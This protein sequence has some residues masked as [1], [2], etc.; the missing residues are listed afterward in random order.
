MM[1][2]NKLL[3]VLCALVAVIAACRKTE[4]YK[5]STK[6][7]IDSRIVSIN[8]GADTTKFIVYA[9]GDWSMA[10]VE[11][12]NWMKLTTSS[13]SGKG[14]A[15]AELTDN[16]ANLPRFVRLVV[17]ADGKTDTIRL[18]QRGL[19]PT[20]AIADLTAQ[21]IANGG[22]FKTPINTNIPMELMTV[23][24]TARTEGQANWISNLRIDKGYLYFKADTNRAATPRTTMVRLSYLDALNV[25]V[26]DTIAI[27]QLPG[28]DY[29][30]AT[31]RDFDYVKQTL[32][33][34]VVNES[35]FIEGVVIS[36]KGHPNMAQ[37]QNTPANKHVLTKNENAIAVYV[38]SM[39]GT[40]GIYF[41]TKTPGDN[42][43]NINDRVKIWLKGATVERYNDPNRTIVT[44][45][46]TMHI[47]AKDEGTPVTPREKYMSELT[48]NDLYTLIKLKDVEISIP[49]G[50][51]TN[52]NEGYTARMDCYPTSI[53][54]IQGGSM[55]MLT[56]LDVPYRRDGKQVPQGSGSISGV[57][58]HE[59]MDRFGGNIGRYSIRHMKRE[60]IA[61]QE[62]RS[63]GFSNVLVEWSRFRNEF[64]A[65][66]TAEANPLTPEIGKGRIYHSTR[67]P[68]DF[69]SNGNY[70]TTD[71]NGLAQDPT[72]LKGSVT[73]GGWGSRNWWPAG[74]TTGAYWSIE[75]STTGITKPISL[76]IEGNTDIGG[77]RNFVVEWSGDNATW[78][79][80]GTF[81][82]ED[83][84]NWSNT[85]L[86]Q[87]PGYKAVNFQFPVEA[88]GLANLYIRV[89]V[90]NKN[91]GTSTSATGGTLG[92]TTNSRLGHVSIKYNK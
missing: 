5:F 92:A 74:A 77:P 42:I 63:A 73:N 86:T 65:T 40:R 39:D 12:V 29:E 72:T 27:S 22:T 69:T 30:G 28:R 48:D 14:Q 10:P 4:Y 61:L 3:F 68:L 17:K 54:D 59:K 20:L 52:I 2:R 38:Q 26:T 56:N 34:G 78:R 60:D 87:I 21:S 31:V 16:S 64:N 13:G 84:A 88:S 51:F 44:G 46:E 15:V 82:F 91:V 11:E 33:A 41:K 89:R 8:A 70:A 25:T 9:D 71:Y 23:V 32:A 19:V 76:Q 62:D 67:Q 50:S 53:R 66:P 24:Q 36:D 37:N 90:A 18:Q 85:L 1:K 6:L 75:T 79:S 55:Y 35:I 45:I 57:L 80:V 81:T 58:V 47:M 7:A 49:S 83:V 43:F